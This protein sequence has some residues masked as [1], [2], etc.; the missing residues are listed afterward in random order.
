VAVSTDALRVWF[1]R[2]ASKDDFGGQLWRGDSEDVPA[3]RLDD[4]GRWASS[5]NGFREQIGMTVSVAVL[6]PVQ[7]D[8][9]RGGVEE[10]LVSGA[11]WDGSGEW[12]RGMVQAEG[13]G[14]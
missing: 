7:G 4:H 5:G 12:L 3:E 11:S 1:R 14:K 10:R 8:G 2:S 9:S 6:R 13:I